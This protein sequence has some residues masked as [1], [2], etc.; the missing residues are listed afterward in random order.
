MLHS[1]V[2]FL[3]AAVLG[4]TLGVT[5]VMAGAADLPTPYEGMWYDADRPGSGFVVDQEDDTVVVTFFTYD[6]EGAPAWYLASGTL[7]DGVLEGEAQKFE[8]G[9]CLNCAFVEPQTSGSVPFR[10]EFDAHGVGWLSWNDGERRSG[11]ALAFSSPGFSWFGDDVDHGVA[12]LF[13][14]TGRWLYVDL[15][16]FPA[17]EFPFDVQFRTRLFLD[18][19]GILWQ[20]R[21]EDVAPG[22]EAY[23]LTCFDD[24][25]EADQHPQC[26]LKER[27]SQLPRLRP[28]LFS[29]FWAD[30]GPQRLYGYRQSQA[31]VQPEE[32]RGSLPVLG[33]RLTG[34]LGS[35]AG[36]G[37]PGDADVAMDNKIPLYLKKGMWVIPGQPGNGLMLDWQNEVVVATFFTYREDGTAVWYQGSGIV[38]NAMVSFDALEFSGGSCL[39]CEYQAPSVLDDPVKATL[40]FKSKS[41]AVLT[42]DGGEPV[43]LRALAFDVPVYRSFGEEG[44][45]GQPALYDLRGRWIFVDPKGPKA[46]FRDVTFASPGRAR[47]GRSLSWKDESGETMIRCDANK[48][49]YESP[50]CRFLEH[51]GQNWQRAFSIHWADIGEDQIIGYREP[52]LSGADGKTRGEDAI[53]GFRLSGPS[54]ID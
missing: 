2:R 27:G 47:T 40:E 38:E 3:F 30:I 19:G 31:F 23:E 8:G 42:F 37:S 7:E 34:P 25:T 39:D 50:Q 14:P 33:F 17:A 52:P 10:L 53:L 5:R 15:S 6:H 29:A 45:F 9:A 46:F 41:T 11:R 43:P 32:L 22:E 44:S 24:G 35:P 20:E 13:D 54:A 36:A 49:L 18:P 12:A 26:E 4:C 16:A 21:Y 48:S 28:T 1:M 51:D